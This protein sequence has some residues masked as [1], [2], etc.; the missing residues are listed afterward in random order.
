MTSLLR[1]GVDMFT[2]R[3]D[4]SPIVR[5]T[6][7]NHSCQ[8]IISNS[9][10]PPSGAA[11]AM[12]TLGSLCAVPGTGPSRSGERP[13]DLAGTG[14]DLRSGARSGGRS[15]QTSMTRQ[16]RPLRPHL[17][18]Y[19]QAAGR[20]SQLGGSRA[21]PP[22]RDDARRVGAQRSRQADR[23][24]RGVDPTRRAIPITHVGAWRRVR[25]LRADDVRWGVA[26]QELPRQSRTQINA[27][28]RVERTAAQAGDLMYYP[29]HVMMFSASAMRWCTAQRGAR[30]RSRSSPGATPATSPS[31]TQLL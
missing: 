25:L 28:K 11:V 5:A 30:S 2:A 20:S 31:P 19:V 24:A 12:V 27:S 8:H 13:V 18:R 26:G 6:G 23:A 14:A 1:F 16:L 7:G 4:G 22:G 3:N 9:H 10:I 17:R 29:G 21:R 15:R